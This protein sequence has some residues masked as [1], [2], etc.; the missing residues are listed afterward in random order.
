MQDWL[1]L[2][3]IE[4]T[5][6]MR[7]LGRRMAQ[8]GTVRAVLDRARAFA[9]A[10]A[11]ALPPF[12]EHGKVLM[13]PPHAPHQ[14]GPQRTYLTRKL[15]Q[16][17]WMQA[18]D[19]VHRKG[20]WVTVLII[21]LLFHITLPVRKPGTK[22]C[23]AGE[24]AQALS[25]F[26]PVTYGSIKSQPLGCAQVWRLADGR[27]DVQHVLGGA[28]GSPWSSSGRMLLALRLPPQPEQISVGSKLAVGV[29]KAEAGEQD[30]LT[31]SLDSRGTP[32]GHGI[33]FSQHQGL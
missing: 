11:E 13:L 6:E 15:A 18:T 1:I 23:K 3:K 26:R 29:F 21:Q 7:Y 33:M 5:E 27:R 16:R 10:T 32:P 4:Y 22:C 12:P 17:H 30:I 14:Q 28:G 31:H 2:H 25:Q 24:R 20:V 8:C 19:V 9:V